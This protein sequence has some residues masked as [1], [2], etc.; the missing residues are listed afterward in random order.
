LPI[1]EE[2]YLKVLN[3]KRENSRLKVVKEE[4][5]VDTNGTFGSKN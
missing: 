2:E 4:K 1:D 3:L 5:V